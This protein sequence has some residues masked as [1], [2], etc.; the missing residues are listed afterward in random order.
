MAVTHCLCERTSFEDIL[1]WARERGIDSQDAVQ[2][3]LGCGKHCG[4][5]VPFIEY[6]LATGTTR[7]PWPCPDLPEAP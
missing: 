4:I 3:G 5:C 2:S 6:A 1:K 7:V